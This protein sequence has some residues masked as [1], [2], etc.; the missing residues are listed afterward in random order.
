[1]LNGNVLEVYNVVNSGL[2][3]NSTISIAIDRDQNKWITGYGLAK[4]IGNK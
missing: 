2:K 1:M 3:S 4:Y